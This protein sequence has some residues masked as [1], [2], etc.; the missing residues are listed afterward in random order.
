MLSLLAPRR[1]SLLTHF[2]SANVYSIRHRARLRASHR[3]GV[4]IT[5]R[6][7]AFSSSTRPRRASFEARFTRA[8]VIQT[9]TDVPFARAPARD[10]LYYTARRILTSRIILLLLWPRDR[11][12]GGL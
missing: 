10:L 3:A 4:E 1:V 6:R 9:S 11:L 5:V 12:R 8:R 7:E 2:L